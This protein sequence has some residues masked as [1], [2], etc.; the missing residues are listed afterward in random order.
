MGKI[1]SV[2]GGKA[3]IDL[4]RSMGVETPALERPAKWSR[5]TGHE[6]SAMSD[7]IGVPGT[8]IID[9]RIE[10][11]RNP[12]IKPYYARGRLSVPG[13]LEET[14]RAEPVVFSSLN[15]IAALCTNAL[16]E[17][18]LSPDADAELV[19]IV[20]D[21]HNSI[22]AQRKSRVDATTAFRF[23]FATFEPSWMTNVNNRV[24]LKKLGFREQATV[25]R[26]LF[27]ERQSELVGAEFLTGG[28]QMARYILPRGE[29]PEDMRLVVC[30]VNSTGNNVEG[31][32]PVR[33]IVGLRKLK[34]LLLNISG[35]SYQKYGVPIAQI[36]RELVASTAAELSQLGANS[37][38]D[39]IRT[40]ST[41][42]QSIEAQIAPV[43][44]MPIGARVDYVTPASQMPDIRPMLEYI[45]AL[46]ALVF[47][48]EGALLG[49]QGFGS[50]AM[51]SVAD[52]RFMRSAP[53]YARVIADMYT[54]LLH[55][56][57]RW[58]HSDPD[59]IEEWPEYGYRFAGTQD[60]TRWA[61]D[62]QVLASA[63]VWTW[64]DA[65]RRMAAANMGLPPNAFD[66]WTGAS[67]D[68]SGQQVATPTEP[69]APVDVGK[70]VVE[71]ADVA[72]T[73]MNGAQIASLVTVVQSIAAGTLPLDSGIE[74]IMKAFQVSREEALRIIGA[75]GGA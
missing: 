56:M 62:M 7:E 3:V 74:I 73:A 52:N 17:P 59:S 8:R 68:V 54:E 15:S 5:L 43:L 42:L 2:L 6:L 34:E 31:V 70:P 32:S 63:Q 23:G 22:R 51:A 71:V 65:A 36:V 64:P 50:Y 9:G 10:V 26:W 41:R 72:A 16:Y 58:N 13:L 40:L 47:S 61:A 75:A 12:R 48:N 67:A 27:D 20:R 44:P 28:A 18:V 53:V 37:S 11:E 69:D 45:D 46:M 39:E 21:A 14:Y 1:E 66:D 30:S 19:A 60:S 49:S 57:I 38:D 24:V 25:E 55:W 35:V 4:Y 29:T 33:V